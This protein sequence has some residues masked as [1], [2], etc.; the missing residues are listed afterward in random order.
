MAT[1]LNDTFTTPTSSPT[2]KSKQQS[3]LSGSLNDIGKNREIY[4]WILSQQAA[5]RS[6]LLAF[7]KKDLKEI[8]SAL[9]DLGTNA[10]KTGGN[11]F[12]QESLAKLQE[13]YLDYWKR[14]YHLINPE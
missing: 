8:F 14:S 12:A 4:E 6:E 13:I 5:L 2:T 7:F 10:E 1:E 3:V 11:T 9:Q